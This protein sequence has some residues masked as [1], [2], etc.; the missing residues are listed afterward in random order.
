MVT[1]EGFDRLQPEPC[2]FGVRLTE[3]DDVEFL[4]E[5]ERWKLPEAE[6]ET[7]KGKIDE[8]KIGGTPVFLQGDEFPFEQNCRLLLQLDACSVPFSINFG[9][10]G[11]GY[12]FLNEKGDQAKFLWQCC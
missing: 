11:V 5:P 12:A 3:Q 8:N 10:S 7:V 6:R 4:T 1:R 9:D 2:E